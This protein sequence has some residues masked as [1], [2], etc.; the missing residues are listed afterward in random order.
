M[1]IPLAPPKSR[2]LL[3]LEIYLFNKYKF[4][5][6]DLLSIRGIGY[7][8]EDDI[9]NIDDKNMFDKIIKIIDD[10]CRMPEVIE[11]CGHA[12]YIGKKI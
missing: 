3:S 10:T 2:I 12:M 4:S 5:K 1:Y 9:Y 8:K 11:M 6:I 7:E